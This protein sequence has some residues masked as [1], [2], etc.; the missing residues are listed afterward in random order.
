[1]TPEEVF[2][3]IAHRRGSVWL[4]GGSAP[5]GWSIL[6]WDPTEVRTDGERWP[7]AGRSR[8]R[9]GAS[10][11][12]FSGGCIGYIGY[13]AGHRVDLVP[14]EATTT[15]PEIWL[16]RYRGGLC[17]RHRDRTWHP[18]G[19]PS[20][21][22]EARDLLEA[23][24]PLAEPLPA[25]P[26]PA[27]ITTPRDR[28]EAAV[29]Q[30]LELIAAGDCY[31]VNLSRPV[32]LTG[33]GAPWPAYRR[34]RALSSPA[35]GAFLRLDDR[36][37]VLS[38]SPELFLSVRGDR[39][40]S[41]PVKGTRPRGDDPRLDEALAAELRR[42]AKDRAELT[43]IVDLVRN[44]LGRIAVAGTVAA[45]RRRIDAHANVFHAS[46]RV[47]ATLKPELDA[48]DAL[49][50]SFPPGSVT[51]APKIRACERIHELEQAPRGVYC[52]AIGYVADGGDATWSVAIRTAVW[53]GEDVRYHVGGGIV[54]AS[55]PADEWEET[56]S[57]G[58]AL[59]AA[60]RGY[61]SNSSSASPS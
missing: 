55:V 51:G 19:E 34:L 58:T 35:Y 21:V 6:T 54:A 59:A 14:P 25:P 33:A 7:D 57:K 36:T 41:E 40:V 13:G 15:E 1:M 61:S 12:P 10:D 22:A 47:S 44:D 49:A 32:Q 45:D 5:T 11:A 17:Y 27:P 38:N 28:Y 9:S 43:M 23:A 60:L 20:F 50:A 52:G 16:G 29:G 53:S 39:V 26:G 2:A 56:V 30:L 8:V 18:A 24:G 3:K 31:Q 37:C 42:S 4:D 46:W 48:W